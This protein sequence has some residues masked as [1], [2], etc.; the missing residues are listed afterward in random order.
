MAEK[1]NVKGADLRVAAQSRPECRPGLFQE[2]LL[3]Q[4]YISGKTEPA[5]L[6][7]VFIVDTDDKKLTTPV[8]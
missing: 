2:R 3:V 5:K 6:L 4:L 1:G 7:A 8:K